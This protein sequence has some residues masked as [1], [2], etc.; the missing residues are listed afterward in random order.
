MLG[1]L[2]VQIVGVV[3]LGAFVGAVVAGGAGFA[4]ALA[5]SA[6]WLHALDPL[7]T[8][9]LVVACGT[10]LHVVLIWPVR[11]AI[12]LSRFWPFA[13]GGLV[14]IPIGVLLLMRTDVEGLKTALG[15][16][17][18]VYGVYAV[19]TPRLPTVAAGGRAVD[20]VVGFLGGVLGGLGGFSGVLPTIW[21]Q[22]RGWSKESSRG[23]YQPF[24][25]MA[26]IATLGFVGA[27]VVDGHK[28]LLAVSALPPLFAGAWLGW[29]IYGRLDDSLFRRILAG[30]LL[31][32]GLTLIG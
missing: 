9:M 32:S 30:L 17:L 20:T 5:A 12:E 14:G 10:I 29:R 2:T 13:V 16:F 1:G 25:L 11:R 24:I 22:M 3:W 7:H 8:T 26:N 6:I 18:V 4:F 21:T 23:V 15:G 31:L 28:L 19:V 27:L